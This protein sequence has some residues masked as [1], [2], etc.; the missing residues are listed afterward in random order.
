ML[1]RWILLFLLFAPNLLAQTLAEIPCA[2]RGD[3]FRLRTLQH[4]GQ[5]VVSLEDPE[6]KRLV[7]STFARLQFSTSGKTLYVYL[8]GRETVWN[9]GLAVFSKDGRELEAPGR[10]WGEPAVMQPEALFAALGLRARA[11]ETGYQLQP[12]VLGLRLTQAGS[13]ELT[14]FTSA[15]VKFVASEPEPGRVQVSLEQVGWEAGEREQVL[16]QAR[17]TVQGEP[18]DSK[19]YLEFR[20][21]PFWSAQVKSGLSREILVRPE[22]RRVSAP[23]NPATLAAVRSLGREIE[24]DFDVPV[25]FFWALHQ[26]KLILAVPG[27]RSQVDRVMNFEAAGVPVSQFEVDVEEGSAFEFYSPEGRPLTLGVRLLPGKSPEEW[28]GAGYLEGFQVASGGL[29]VLDA[30]HGGGDPGCR[31]RALGVYEKDIT[32]DI[33]LRLQSILQERGWR[34]EMTRT[35]DRDVTYAGSPDLMELK[36]RADVANRIGADLFVSI[37][38]NASVSSAVRGSSIYW[39]KPQDRALAQYLDVLDGSLGFEQDGLIQNN[40]AVLRLSTMPS[41]LVETA[42]LTH[43]VEGRLLA[44]PAIRQR[45]AEKLADGLARYA[46]AHLKAK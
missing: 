9:H 14:L 1:T 25:Q 35:T 8:P 10:F 29:V 42:Y 13:N 16:G 43:P 6:V 23:S 21:L 19:L 40:F 28:H 26:Q 7:A 5:A 18:G 36:A 24:L 17:V 11:L 44:T 45:I 33:C 34:V 31:N 39:W 37:H 30:G 27:A 2:F 22:L 3:V 32:L 46:A 41:V 12:L 15:P 38:C 20:F 4:E